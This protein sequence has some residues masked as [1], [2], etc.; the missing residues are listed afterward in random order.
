MA[1][2]EEGGRVRTRPDHQEIARDVNEHIRAI[3]AGFRASHGEFLCECDQDGCI[4]KI[5]LPLS[6]YD[7]L[8]DGQD[9]WRL[10]APK[11]DGAG[12]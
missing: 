7:A 4:E 9:G 11:H 12:F 1:R 6:N 10:V 8:R 3:L 5:V 2:K